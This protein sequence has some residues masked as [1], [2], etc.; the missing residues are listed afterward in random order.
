LEAQ[1]GVIGV[2]VG[3]PTPVAFL[4]FGG[5]KQSQFADIKT[6]GRAIIDFYTEPKIITERY[7]PEN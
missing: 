6:Q 4:P 1:A 5:M 2:N 7:W 3:I